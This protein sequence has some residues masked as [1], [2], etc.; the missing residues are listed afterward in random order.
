MVHKFNNDND[1]NIVKRAIRNF[2][3]SINYFCGKPMNFND[4]LVDSWSDFYREDMNKMLRN[5]HGKNVDFWSERI[6]HQVTH[7]VYQELHIININHLKRELIEKNKLLENKNND[8]MNDD[9]LLKI[10]QILLNLDIKY[11]NHETLDEKL[12]KINECTK[13]LKNF[14]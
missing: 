8:L 13:Y 1:I 9:Q 3:H 5:I 14:I 2:I 11:S 4:K 6:L 10:D 7:R 12:N